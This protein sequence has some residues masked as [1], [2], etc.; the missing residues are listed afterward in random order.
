MEQR[1][2]SRFELDLTDRQRSALLLYARN[3]RAVWNWALAARKADYEERI[4]PARERG[5]KVRGLGWI[6]Q[7]NA[8]LT[9][10]AELFPHWAEVS[11]HV[12][13]YAVRD[14]DKAYK[15]W[16]KGLKTQRRCG[17]PRF[18]RRGEHESF[19]LRG[20]LAVRT[21]AS[22]R[23]WVG[24][25]RIGWLRLKGD[26]TE[27]L[28]GATIQEAT[29]TE[30][31]GRWFVSL[32]WKRTV[33]E[34]VPVV[35]PVIGIDLGLAH[36][37]TLSDGRVIESPRPL[38]RRLRRLRRL[39]RA[40]AR[41]RTAA[42][43]SGRAKSNRCKKR[44]LRR[45]RLHREVANTRSNWLHETTTHLAA[46][47]SKIGIEDLNLSGLMGRK[48]HLGR[49]FADLGAAEL[50]R[51]LEYKTAK[52]G[53]TLVIADRFYPS[54]RL[55]SRCGTKK[56]DLT[57]S[58]R[59]YRCASCGLVIDRDLN[60]A[61][62]LRSVAAMAA[63][64]LNARGGVVRPGRDAGQTPLNREPGPEIATYVA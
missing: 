43:A 24:L 26:D 35:G 22:G 40:I 9:V 18:H 39:D 8:W 60:A 15:A 19:R 30:Q 13:I 11:A 23:H 53:S 6:D 25:P 41:Q 33:T 12:A 32:S 56:G 55:C 50:R 14:L 21:T 48:R 49:A 31:A 5:E 47:A 64:T 44:E 58:D 3:A 27:R 61:R 16:W 38:R 1:G 10:R 46:T 20:A 28:A 29:I 34:P 7:Q 59:T 51:Q 63:E 2:A 54:S 37:L 42:K 17:P 57:L 62:N 52:F 36:S 4:K 45:A